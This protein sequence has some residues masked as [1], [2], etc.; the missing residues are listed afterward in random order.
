MII[1]VT[2]H[3]PNGL[4]KKYG[5]N[6]DNKAWQ[7]LKNKME[8]T[9]K[10]CYNLYAKEHEELTLVSGMALGVDQAFWQIAEKLRREN[11]W[12]KI[13]AAVPCKDQEANW[14]DDSK[15]QY[16]RML[17]ESNIV[18]YVSESTYDANCMDKRNEYMVDKSDVVIAV[19][20]KTTGGTARCVKY[21]KRKNKPIIIINPND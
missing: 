4:A 5:Y 21:A 7:A 2:G 16:R 9:I 1:T 6:L 20:S 14:F 15:N 3:R 17:E 13:E 8:L 10:A 18:T 12:I 11:N 19:I